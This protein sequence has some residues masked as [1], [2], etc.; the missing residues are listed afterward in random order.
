MPD[1]T[2]EGSAYAGYWAQDIYSVNDHFG[3]A[4]DLVALSD[5]LHNKNMVS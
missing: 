2:A 4:S 5:A 1:D 3:A